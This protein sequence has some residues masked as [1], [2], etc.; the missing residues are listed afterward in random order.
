MKVDISR[1]HHYPQRRRLPG[2]ANYRWRP[3]AQ[4]VHR[5]AG[6]PRPRLGESRSRVS[7]DLDLNRERQAEEWSEALIGDS[8]PSGGYAPR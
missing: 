8:V 6:A 1:S 7:G 5:R 4:R 3:D 2:Y